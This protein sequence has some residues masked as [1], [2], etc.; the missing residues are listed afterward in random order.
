MASCAQDFIGAWQA[1]WQAEVSQPKETRP[2]AQPEVTF[3][4][5]ATPIQRLAKAAR[6]VWRRLF[7]CAPENPIDAIAREMRKRLDAA[8]R[9]G[10]RA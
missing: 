5:P 9:K 4:M 3:P 7:N 2:Q 6:S 8:E 1:V 10:P